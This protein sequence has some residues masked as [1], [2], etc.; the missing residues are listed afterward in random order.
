VWGPP[1]PL[2]F[3]FD[4]GTGLDLRLGSSTL[5]QPPPSS[6]L[7][8]M[9]CNQVQRK[10]REE[11]QGGR[12]FGCGRARSVGCCNQVGKKGGREGGLDDDVRPGWQE[13]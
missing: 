11:R 3:H 2:R 7:V 12:G 4:G 5:L 13:A 8:L 1:D 10:E 9:M 6:I